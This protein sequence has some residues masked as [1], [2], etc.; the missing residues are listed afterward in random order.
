M[1][2]S[3]ILFYGN[4]PT[5]TTKRPTAQDHDGDNNVHTTT[6]L[7]SHSLQNHRQQ[8]IQYFIHCLKNLPPQYIHLDTNRLTLVHFAV[9][10]LDILRFFDDEENLEIYQLN[11]Q[12]II[13]WIYSFQIVSNFE[14]R[15][16]RKESYFCKHDYSK[17]KEKKPNG[18]GN[19]DQDFEDENDVDNDSLYIQ[20]NAGF[21][22][23]SSFSLH[24]EVPAVFQNPKSKI[25]T[26]QQAHLA[27]TYSA[28]CTLLT[29][30]DDLYRI[31]KKSIIQSM[32]TLQLQNGS[33]Q[34]RSSG[35]ET[36][37][38]FL[39]CACAIS[40]LL[41]DWSGVDKEKAI[42]YIRSCRSYDGAYGLIPGQEGHGG[43][44]YCAVA[45]LSLMGEL[46]NELGQVSDSSCMNS[47][48]DELIQWCVFRQLKGMQGRPNKNEDTCYSFWIGA[49]LVLLGY[50]H[51]L[52]QK[53]LNDFVLQCQSDLGGFSKLEY[54]AYP[55]LLHSF[56]SL[57]WL[58][59]SATNNNDELCETDFYLHVLNSSLGI[60]QRHVQHLFV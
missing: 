37:L 47:Y 44:T 28:I 13:D 4:D 39:Y 43:S 55:D 2:Q 15:M 19:N 42:E 52:D 18:L 48:K 59:L 29:L 3:I 14:K 1:N 49:C 46:D 45:S 33:F 5:M 26:Y 57:A 60:C 6:N 7:H 24:V 11:K 31:D 40:C 25:K 21:Q 32:K 53:S 16:E 17:N 20:D 35:S 34:C 38:R 10:S 56:Y 30:G 50:D 58:S 22:G 51:I 23:G 41:N 27:S 12:H 36:D 8:H 9:Q 54:G